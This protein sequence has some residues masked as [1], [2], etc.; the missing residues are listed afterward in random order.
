M[1]MLTFQNA[2]V[3]VSTRSLKIKIIDRVNCGWLVFRTWE[4]NPLF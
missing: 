2:W 4:S 1:M 3:L